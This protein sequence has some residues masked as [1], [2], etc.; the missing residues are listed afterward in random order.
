MTTGQCIQRARKNAGLSQ[1]QLG[2][3]LGLSASMIGQ[4]ENDLRN[5]KYETLK[6]I[7]DALGVVWTELV[8]EDERDAA[9]DTENDRE[10]SLDEIVAKFYKRAGVVPG[11]KIAA[12]MVEAEM[13]RARVL[14]FGSDEER[15]DYFYT[16][17]NTDGKF[18]ARMRM[19]HSLD[20]A[21]VKEIADYVEHLSEIPQYQR[22]SPTD[23]PQSPQAPQ[24]TDTTEAEKPPT[25][26]PVPSAD[27]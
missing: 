7:A 12:Y 6:R 9:H 3:K 25:D 15:I 22:Y 16:L 4:W 23:T 1:K 8:S 11:Q 19:I 21:Q 18:N 14:I 10:L 5:P 20:P 24:E 26:A 27:K 13:Y 2:E 17:L